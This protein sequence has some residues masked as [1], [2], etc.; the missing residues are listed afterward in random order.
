[1]AAADAV[2]NQSKMVVRS[3]GG[4]NSKRHL[5]ISGYSTSIDLTCD[6]LFKMPFDSE[7]CC[8]V[9]V[10]YYTPSSFTILEEDTDWSPMRS[11]WGT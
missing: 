7:K 8:A 1:M 11:T 5:L 3:S 10:H 4:N 9:S 6:P 2:D